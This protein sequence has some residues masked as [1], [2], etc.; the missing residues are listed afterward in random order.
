MKQ[1]KRPTMRKRG[2]GNKKNDNDDKKSRRLNGPHVLDKEGF[3]VIPMNPVMWKEE[4]EEEEIF[5]A[6]G[7][8]IDEQQLLMALSDLS[9]TKISSFTPEEMM[10]I[11]SGKRLWKDIEETLNH[12]FCHYLIGRDLQGP[13]RGGSAMVMPVLMGGRVCSPFSSPARSNELNW[14]SSKEWEVV[15]NV[16][17]HPQEIWVQ[18]RS[19][20]QRSSPQV[21]YQDQE[22]GLTKWMKD[23]AKMHQQQSVV[24]VEIPPHHMVIL[25]PQLLRRKCIRNGLCSPSI[26]LNVRL[27]LQPLLSKM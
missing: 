13:R 26:E 18:R 6:H 7:I 27:Y 5:R 17:H 8:D 16:S 3:M 4:E 19:H 15:P 21:L 9:S 2:D 24:R 20:W 11:T 1:L 22:A 10:A 23:M 25:H 14:N 12:V